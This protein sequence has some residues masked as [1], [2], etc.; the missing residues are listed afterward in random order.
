MALPCSIGFRLLLQAFRTANLPLSQ[1]HRLRRSAEL[2]GRNDFSGGLLLQ[3]GKQ[4]RPH[5]GHSQGA[6]CLCQLLVL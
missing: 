2:S 3:V 6:H 5:C 1:I 4:E